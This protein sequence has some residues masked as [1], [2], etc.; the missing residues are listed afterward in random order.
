MTSISF[1]I[2]GIPAP[3]GSKNQFG[4]E[5][6]PRTKPWR[7]SVAAEAAAAMG[8][9]TLHHGPVKLTIR[10]GFPRPKSH[11]RTGRYSHLLRDDAP[12][13][14]DTAPDLDKLERAVLDALSGICYRD[15]RQVAKT[16]SAKFFAE[17]SGVW[18]S[19]EPLDYKLPTS[20]RVRPLPQ[21]EAA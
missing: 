21:E 12:E 10:F 7:A 6:N 4:S 11:Y 3:Q 17:K 5:S 9:R 14:K 16:D 1:T 13:W 15:D 2:Y 20:A 19:V 8:D 18:I